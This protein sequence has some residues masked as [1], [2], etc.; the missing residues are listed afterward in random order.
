MSPPFVATN[1][2][3]DPLRDRPGRSSARTRF[4]NRLTLAGVA[5]RCAWAAAAVAFLS[6]S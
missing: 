2:K 4:A 1:T 6:G 3:P 5:L